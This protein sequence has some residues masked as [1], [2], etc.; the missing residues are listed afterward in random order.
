MVRLSYIKVVEFQARGLVHLHVVLR[1]DGGAGPSERAAGVARR[2]TSLT[3]AVGRVVC[4]GRRARPGGRHGAD[5]AGPA[6]DPS[7]TSGCSLAGDDA[8]ATA[9]AAY[10]AKY[11]TKT[12]DGTPWLAHPIRTRAQIERLG[13]APPH[14]GHGQD[15]LGARAAPEPRPA[16]PA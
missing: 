2:R 1:A 16:A 12:A 10:V 8:D 11:A 4:R 9:I 13:A 14:R 6:G 5:S 7:T 15:G 3:E